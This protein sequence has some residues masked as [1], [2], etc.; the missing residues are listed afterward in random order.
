VVP[1]L[2][3][4]VNY[5][6]TTFTAN[7]GT[8]YH[9]WLRLRADS[10]S[11]ANDSLHVQFSDALTS[12]GT[13][14]ARIGTTASAEVVL[15]AG[16]TAPAPHGWGWAD[17]GWDTAGAPIYFAT[18]GTHTIR[19]QQRE[20]GMTIDQIVL[21]P[22]AYLSAA[23]G[24]RR[25]DTT[26]LNFTQGTPPPPP[27]SSGTIVL[28]PGTL[29]ASQVTGRWQLVS[30]STA[31]GG[32]AIWNP[33]LSQAKIAPALA[34]PSSFV[35]MT[36]N[37][38]AGKPYHVWLRMKAQNNATSNDSV[39]L[40]FNDSVD[41]GGQPLARIGTTSSAEMILQAGSS[42]QVP[43]GWGWADNSWDTPG[44]NVYFPTSGTHT[45]RIQQRED[46]PTIDQIVISP[47]AYLTTSPGARRNDAVILAV[48]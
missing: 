37:A 28:R 32:S 48:Q 24:A 5:F 38:D 11:T 27:S 8:A 35:Q 21:S 44:F 2:A 47:D 4:P 25:D 16:S 14:Y 12:S 7:A 17:N 33:D 18:T 20:D 22:D 39:H 29:P 23:P 6:Q 34:S 46:G 13:P 19:I 36:F 41:S 45:L 26:I 15:Q 10:N 40:Q 3:S 30:D 31:A 42:G 1:A 9:L 43:S